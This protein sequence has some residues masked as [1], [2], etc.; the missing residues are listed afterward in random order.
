MFNVKLYD[1]IILEEAGQAG[2]ETLYCN[3]SYIAVLV[4]HYIIIG[5]IPGIL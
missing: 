2:A 3:V 5:R 1:S 4:T